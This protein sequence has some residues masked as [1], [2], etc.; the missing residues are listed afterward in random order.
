MSKFPELAASRTPK[1]VAVP[2][3]AVG[4][5]N[6]MAVRLLVAPVVPVEAPTPEF[7]VLRKFVEFAVTATRA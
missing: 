1:C 2:Q 4:A 6:V 3:L 5:G 7:C